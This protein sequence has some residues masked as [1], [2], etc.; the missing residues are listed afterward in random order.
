MSEIFVRTQQTPLVF[1]GSWSVSAIWKTAQVTHKALLEK[2][3]GIREIGLGDIYPVPYIAEISGKSEADILQALYVSGVMALIDFPLE[4]TSKDDDRFIQLAQM[5]SREALENS[6]ILEDGM[7]RADL[8]KSIGINIWNGIGLIG[9]IED[10]ALR[11]SREP[12]NSRPVRGKYIT[13][14]LWN[15]ASWKIGDQYRI[16]GSSSSS[17]AACASWGYSLLEIANA[18]EAWQL[19]WWVVWGAESAALTL[20]GT[21]FDWMMG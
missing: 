5:S 11:L 12:L 20:L 2:R 4:G 13:S 10:G 17:N 8:Q 14:L 6:W 18:I 21:S 9:T 7:L 1:I 15:L 16:R 3:S 19:E